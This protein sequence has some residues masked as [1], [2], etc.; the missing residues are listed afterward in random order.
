MIGEYDQSQGAVPISI[1]C[2]RYSIYYEGFSE[3]ELNDQQKFVKA[4]VNREVLEP[5]FHQ[6]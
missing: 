6:K 5:I 4:N 3:K 1:R 2:W